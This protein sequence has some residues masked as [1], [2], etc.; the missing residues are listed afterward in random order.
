MGN[1]SLYEVKVPEKLSGKKLEQDTLE[2]YFLHRKCPAC[3]KWC[4]QAHATYLSGGGLASSDDDD[5]KKN[6]GKKAMSIIGAAGKIML[7]V[8]AACA[9]AAFAAVTAA[10]NKAGGVNEF[11]EKIGS[12]DGRAQIEA[13][14]KADAEEKA[15][16]NIK[17]DSERGIFDRIKGRGAQLIPDGAQQVRNQ[18][19][20]NN[21]KIERLEKLKTNK[22]TAKPDPKQVDEI[23]KDVVKSESETSVKQDELVAVTENLETQIQELRDQ[24]KPLYQELRTFSETQG[25]TSVDFVQQLPPGVGFQSSADFAVTGTQPPGDPVQS[26]AIVAAIQQDQLFNESRVTDLE[27]AMNTVTPPAASPF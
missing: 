8:V 4:C 24:N 17:R 1:D 14:I 26:S 6:R 10:V 25:I 27:D 13:E 16:E 19:A 15:K 11:L 9:L 18:I 7:L 21:T 12:E 2:R 5:K 3:G 22:I 23:N 20:W